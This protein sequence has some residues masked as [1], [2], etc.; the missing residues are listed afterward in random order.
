MSELSKCLG[1]PDPLGTPTKSWPPAPHLFHE[2]QKEFC[3][4]FIPFCFQLTKTL[5]SLSLCNGLNTWKESL[6]ESSLKGPL[7]RSGNCHAN[8]AWCVY[9][10]LSFVRS[11]SLQRPDNED[12][13]GLCVPIYSVSYTRISRPGQV[14]LSAACGPCIS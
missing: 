13:R 6:P 8:G 14:V 12:N 7:Y 4:S 3:D 10:P 9:S 2:K 5:I 11:F 1:G